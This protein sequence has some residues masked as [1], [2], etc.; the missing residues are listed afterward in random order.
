MGRIRQGLALIKGALELADREGL[1][2]TSIRGRINLSYVGSTEDPV[3]GFRASREAHAIA[4]RTGQRSML[5]FLTPLLAGWYEAR[6]ELDEAEAFATDPILE[7]APTDFRAQTLGIRVE[8]ADLRG[9][10]SL[11]RDLFEQA[12]S[13]YEQSEDTQVLQDFER[14][15]HSR[16]LADGRFQEAFEDSVRLARETTTPSIYQIV[17]ARNAAILTGNVGWLQVVLD[18]YRDAGVLARYH[19]RMAEAMLAF[20]ESPSNETLLRAGVIVEEADDFELV[21]ESVVLCAS[22][23]LHAPPGP[24]QEH[25]EDELRARCDKHGLTGIL[26]TYG[27]LRSVVRGP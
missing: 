16:A 8:V 21:L 17:A 1:A 15:R 22:L 3:M 18:I 11:S 13:L 5:L 4:K 23:A 9:D 6:G 26:D 24:K 14:L 10:H 20:L 25:W 27:T 7:G 2:A 19:T 12:R